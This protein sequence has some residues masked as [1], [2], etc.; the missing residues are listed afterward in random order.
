V[1]GLLSL[2]DVERVPLAERT[3][4]R[5][6]AAM[7]PAVVLAPGDKVADALR[8]LA[9]SRAGHA[10]V[11][12]DGRLVGTLSRSEIGRGLALRELAASQHPRPQGRGGAA[13]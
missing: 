1:V 3:A 9:G 13:A 2:E 5:V 4:T 12:S 10:A 11:V 8:R 7:E 6:R